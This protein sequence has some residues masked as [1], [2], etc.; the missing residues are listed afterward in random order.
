STKYQVSGAEWYSS[1]TKKVGIGEELKM[2]IYLNPGYDDHYD[3]AFRGSY[4]ANNITI[5]GGTFVSANKSNGEL[6]VI[7][8][9]NGVKGQYLAPDEAYWKGSGYGNAVWSMYS[10]NKDFASG[11][12]DVYL[13]H[14]SSVKKRL[15]AYEGTSYNFYPYMTKAGTY[16]FKI[17]TVPKTEAAKKYG[18]KSEWVVSDEVYV[19]AESVSDGSGQT[20][21]NGSGVSPT[22]QVGWILQD[23][24]WYYRYPDSTYQKDSWLKLKDK[25]YLFD[26]DGKMLT[27][28]QNKNG[29]TYFLKETGD[30]QTGWIKGGEKWYY[31]NPSP[32]GIEGAMCKGWVQMTD[33]IYYMDSTGAMVEGWHKVDDNWY[34]FYPQAGYRATNTYVDSFRIDENG[35]W[36]K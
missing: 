34:Y 13:Y 7:V 18:T 36:K 28:W 33:K 11:A 12:Y 30:M 19:G 10:E 21:D 22:G 25:W 35:I 31:L 15:E 8:K 20:D 1:T 24:V 3:Y 29:Q 17:R 9:L 32:Q 4:S 26:K 2:K 5:K 27:G 6:A 14:G 23:A 16:H